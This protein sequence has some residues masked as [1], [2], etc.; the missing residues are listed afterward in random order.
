MGG[1][2]S[3]VLYQ[4]AQRSVR[5]AAG[6]A[7]RIFQPEQGRRSD[8]APEQRYRQAE[9]VRRAVAD[10]VC[11]QRVSH[12][13]RGHFSGQP[14]CQTRHR[15]AVACRGRGA[16]HARHL[17]LGQAEEPRQPAGAR[18]DELGSAGE[19]EQFQSDRG[20]Q[21]GGLF[22]LEIQIG[23]REKFRRIHFSRLCEQHF[24]ARFTISRRISRSSSW[25]HTGSL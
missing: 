7:G 1:A 23:E 18:R 5:E 14:E 9:P 21:P 22:P 4:P 3:R 16:A 24:L 11:G 13:R 6:T 17:G 20:V 10:A 19:P 2:G 15:R 8:F 12:H 25:W